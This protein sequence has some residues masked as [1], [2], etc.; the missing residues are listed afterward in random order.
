MYTCR[1][2]GASARVSQKVCCPASLSATCMTDGKVELRCVRGHGAGWLSVCP[3]CCWYAWRRPTTN[4]PHPPPPP[5]LK[6]PPPP[7]LT[8]SITRTHNQN[9]NRYFDAHV[10]HPASGP[11]G[12]GPKRHK[13]PHHP[14]TLLHHQPQDAATTSSSASAS[15]SSAASLGVRLRPFLAFLAFFCA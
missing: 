7:P 12:R 1:D 6:P 3:C 13:R 4:P 2:G 15:L 8:Q 9:T 11:E 5:P 14:T 10:A